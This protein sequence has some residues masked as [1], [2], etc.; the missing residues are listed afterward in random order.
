M[1][2]RRRADAA[3]EAANAV[4]AVRGDLRAKARQLGVSHVELHGGT[5]A[6]EAPEGG[7]TRFVALLPRGGAAPNGG[8]EGS[9]GPWVGSEPTAAGDGAAWGP[10]TR[11]EREVAA[12]VPS[13]VRP[14]GQAR[15]RMAVRRAVHVQ[16]TGCYRARPAR[17]SRAR[18]ALVAADPAR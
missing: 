17:S 14:R 9:A 12:L 1:P 18:R 10:L 6:V 3:I 13:V 16:W 8:A 4:T 11:R 2:P 5:I 7:G 15:E